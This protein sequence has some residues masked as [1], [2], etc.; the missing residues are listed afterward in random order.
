[1]PLTFYPGVTSPV[2]HP[3]SDSGPPNVIPEGTDSAVAS[4]GGATV[5]TRDDPVTL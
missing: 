5:L 3:I 1:M 4:Q 2:L